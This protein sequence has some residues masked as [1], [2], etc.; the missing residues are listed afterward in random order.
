MPETAGAHRLESRPD[1]ALRAAR[2]VRDAPFLGSADVHAAPAR[3]RPGGRRRRHR[4]HPDRRRGRVPIRC[5]VR[6]GGD[7]QRLRDPAQLQPAAGRGRGRAA[8]PGRLRRRADGAGLDGGLARALDCRARGDR[9]GRRH[10]RLPR[11]R[12]HGAARRAAGARRRA[13]T[14]GAG[15]VR[16]APRSVGRV[17]RA[18][19]LPRER[20]PARAR[21]GPDRPR[22]VDPGRAAR[23]AQRGRGR[24]HAGGAGARR[25]HLRGAGRARSGEVLRAGARTASARLRASSPSTS[26]SSTPRSRPAPGR[27]RW[28]GRR[29]GRR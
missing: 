3:S 23:I 14:A 2:C 16:L 19:A 10:D 18:E 28:A 21:G 17:L 29:A 12:P 1:A 24:G 8:L 9:A 4:R 26:T 27:P 25:A 5:P 22:Q 6:P 7:P 13:R 15:A 11:R 20:R